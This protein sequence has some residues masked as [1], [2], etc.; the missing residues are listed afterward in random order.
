MV[1]KSIVVLPELPKT[2]TGKIRKK[3]LRVGKESS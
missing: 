1:P 2:S 3:D